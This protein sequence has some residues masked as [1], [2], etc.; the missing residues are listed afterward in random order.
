MTTDQIKQQLQDLYVEHETIKSARNQEYHQAVLPFLQDVINPT[1]QVEINYSYQLSVYLKPVD[2]TIT[3]SNL[4][5]IYYRVGY[6]G[7]PE[8]ETFTGLELSYYT[9]GAETTNDR[10]KYELNRL[11]VIGKVA[12]LLLTKEKEML[13]AAQAVYDKYKDSNKEFYYRLG[14]L[15]RR[16][17]Q[18]EDLQR[19]DEYENFLLTA[20][21]EI[22]FPETVSID[23]SSDSAYKADWYNIVSFRVVERSASGKTFTIELGVKSW[24]NEGKVHYSTIKVKADKLRKLYYNYLRGHINK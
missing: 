12:D 18:A 14:D 13:A 2:N 19:Q 7:D 15:Q 23:M 11:Q 3:W 1:I 16:L 10:G 6:R 22:T 20:L 21:K 5:E 9:T 8:Q 17:T 24:H 4:C